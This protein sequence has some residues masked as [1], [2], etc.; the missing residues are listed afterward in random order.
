MLIGLLGLLL[1]FTFSMSNSRF[2]NRRNLII[3]EA[4]IIGTTVLR[5]DIYPDSVRTLLRST[6]REYVERRIAFFEAGMNLEKA[7]IEFEAG[8]QLSAKVWNIATEYAK[9]DHTTTIASQLIPSINEMIDITTERIA[10][11]LATIPD[12]IMY[13]LFI[14]CFCAAFLLG[15]DEI[16]KLDWIVI[17]GFSVTLS[18]TVFIIIDLDR[19]RTGII[20]MAGQHQ[21]L[22]E[23][24][25][26]F[27]ND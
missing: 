6:L 15:Y 7:M 4:N 9:K 17:A 23:L 25:E 8:Q 19:P 13:F 20:T 18:V 10:A 12:S 27:V 1:A 11:G 22:V 26:M 2:D 14:L 16:V 3:T 24:R 21:K 5:T